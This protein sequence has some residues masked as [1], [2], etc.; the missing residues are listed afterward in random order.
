[1]RAK[2]SD[3]R[4]WLAVGFA[5]LFMLILFISPKSAK[6][7]GSTFNKAPD[8]Y[9]AWYAF[10]AQQAIP[11]ERW[12]RP[13]EELFETD[14]KGK[15]GVPTTLLQVQPQLTSEFL[16]LETENWLKQGNTL[17]QLGT[18][19]PV[20]GAT[21]MTRLESPQGQVKVET[22]RRL[23]PKPQQKDDRT[24]LIIDNGLASAVELAVAPSAAQP[25]RLLGD[26]FGAVVWQRSVGKGKV[27]YATTPHLGANAYQDEPGNYAFLAQ[28]V[29]QTGNVIKVDEYLH[30]YKDAKTVASEVAK[31]W[32]DY[33]AKTPLLPIGLQA[34]MM[35][36][37]VIW[38]Q[39]RRFGPPQ[40]IAPPKIDNSEA[41]IQALA[42]VLQKAGSSEFILETVGKTEQLF[43]QRELGLGAIP[44]TLEDLS[45]AWVASGRSATELEQILRTAARQRRLNEVELATWLQMVQTVRQQAQR[46]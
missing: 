5:V 31:S 11:I 38:A 30:G 1:M 39:N 6:T 22:T 32:V 26:R 8:G 14:K 41:Y 12:Q 35:L 27:I 45:Q 17:V 37:V 34:L 16:T 10:M 23:L 46:S 25:E 9:G 29:R 7:A 42:G 44:L 21:F 40:T 4:W 2:L 24:K 19:A 3:R 36:L 33:L 18:T 20:T 13:L 28:L 15:A 43:L